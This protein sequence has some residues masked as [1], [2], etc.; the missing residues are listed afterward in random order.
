MLVLGDLRLFCGEV[1]FSDCVVF[2]MPLIITMIHHREWFS[3]F[4]R[5]YDDLT[6]VSI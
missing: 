6:I 1:I 5:A 2:I 4:L 3:M